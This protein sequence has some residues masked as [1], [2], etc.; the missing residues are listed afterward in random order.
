MVHRLK[1][2]REGREEGVWVRWEEGE[3]SG[4]NRG[5]KKGRVI[6]GEV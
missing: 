5:D 2:D 3:N 1:G 4:E 6:K